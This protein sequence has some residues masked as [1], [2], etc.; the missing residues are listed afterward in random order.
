MED[1]NPLE[2]IQLPDSP[3]NPGKKKGL[4]LN[5]Q[6]ERLIGIMGEQ[7]VKMDKL[8]TILSKPTPKTAHTPQTRRSV[9]KVVGSFSV[10]TPVPSKKKVIGSRA[11]RT[12]PKN[13]R[14]RTR[15]S[16]RSSLS[17]SI[18][19]ESSISSEDSQSSNV[20]SQVNQ[21]LAMLQPNFQKHKGTFSRREERIKRYRPFAFID[22]E[23]QRQVLKR[24]HPE[25]LTFELHLIG[26]CGM[27][28]DVMNEGTSSYGIVQHIAQ[29]LED[30]EYI[31]WPNIRAFSN[32]IVAN[33]A[34]GKWDWSHE[35]AID[36]TRTNQYMRARIPDD[37]GWS[38]PCPR[39]NRGRCEF[40]DTHDV[41][42]VTLRHVCSYCAAN[43]Y[44]NNHT[45][46]ACHRKKN[47]SGAP[48]FQKSTFEDKK[49][50]GNKPQYYTRSDKVEEQSKN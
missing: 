36:R 18:L 21:A 50:K 43:G 24:G 35:K 9:D 23:K 44:D 14:A 25:E 16:S 47:S 31:S 13:G 34:R 7:A 27:A 40:E 6:V 22:R 11:K 4:P 19:E 12:S 3:H 49:E 30:S 10:H 39:Y 17:S 2:A 33:V 46:R 26:L 41:S 28:L 15:P 8:L 42:S 1:T 37:A 20:R 48:N 5:V 38:A 45:N 29:I 32:T